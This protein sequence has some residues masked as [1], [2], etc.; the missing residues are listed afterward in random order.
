M[1]K[2]TVDVTVMYGSSQHRVE[3]E[4]DDEETAKSDAIDSLFPENAGAFMG[5]EDEII[6]VDECL[7]EIVEEA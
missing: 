2:Y 5:C 1:K 6:E 7:A 3:V 4:A